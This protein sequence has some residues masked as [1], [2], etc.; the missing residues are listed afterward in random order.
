MMLNNIQINV[1][2]IM[3]TIY[4]KTTAFKSNKLQGYLSISASQSVVHK[5]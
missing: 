2:K 1:F 4:T 3:V 5:T